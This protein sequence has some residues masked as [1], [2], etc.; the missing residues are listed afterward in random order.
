[1]DENYKA[2]IHV[3]FLK[4]QFAYNLFNQQTKE[5]IINTANE[6]IKKYHEKLENSSNSEY[7]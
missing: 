7:I 4:N 2:Q 3:I 5:E 1:M 6:D